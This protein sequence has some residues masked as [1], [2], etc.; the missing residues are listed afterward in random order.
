MD[1]WRRLQLLQ[2]GIAQQV[3]P[4]FETYVALRY[5]SDVVGLSAGVRAFVWHVRRLRLSDH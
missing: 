3:E 4:L 1:Y 2:P 5:A